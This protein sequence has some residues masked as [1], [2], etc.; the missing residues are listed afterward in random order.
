MNK[1]IYKIKLATKIVGKR[2]CLKLRSFIIAI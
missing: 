2:M 1:S